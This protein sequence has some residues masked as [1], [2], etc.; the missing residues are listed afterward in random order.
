MIDMTRHPVLIVDDEPDILYSLRDLLRREFD[1]HTALNAHQALQILEWQPI[2][3]VLADQ[4]MPGVTGVDL[5][6]RIRREHPEVVR[7]IFTGYADI[8]AVID[9]INKGSVYHYLTKPWDPDELRLVL[10]RACDHYE[11]VGE[12]QHLLRDLRNHLGQC[13]TLAKQRQGAPIETPAEEKLVETGTALLERL[14]RVL[15]LA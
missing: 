14:D 9:A 11:Q 7:L 13:L 3:V 15:V 12:R 5:L 10:R 1:L 6:D 2:H 8:K 4:R